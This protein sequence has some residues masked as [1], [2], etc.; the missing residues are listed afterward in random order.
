MIKEGKWV[1]LWVKGGRG[2]DGRRAPLRGGGRQRR[3]RCK[4]VEEEG[5]KEEAKEEEEEV[6]KEAEEEETEEEEKVGEEHE[7]RKLRGRR[8]KRR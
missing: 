8:R 7:G 5:A 4:E 2:A 1:K 6:K 3:D